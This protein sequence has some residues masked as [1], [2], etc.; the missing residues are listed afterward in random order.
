MKAGLL[1][2]DPHE[3]GRA[4]KKRE[5]PPEWIGNRVCNGPQERL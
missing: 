4:K 3:E 2:T 5:G 1:A